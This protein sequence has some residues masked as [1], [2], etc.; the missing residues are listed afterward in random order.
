MCGAITSLHQTPPWR[1][2]E[3]K[4][5]MRTPLP[6]LIVLAICL[7]CTVFTLEIVLQQQV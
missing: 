2:A 4:K 3:L 1:G 5:S 6:L 7:S